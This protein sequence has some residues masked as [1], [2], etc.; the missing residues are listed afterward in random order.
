LTTRTVALTTLTILLLMLLT[1]SMNIQKVSAENT[2][3][4]KADGSVDPS[5]AQIQRDIDVYT[6]RGDI[7]G[8][9]VI[10][11]NNTII[12]GKDFTL[13]GNGTDS[14]IYSRGTHNLTV[15]NLRI[16]KFSRGVYI[17]ESPNSKITSNIVT[18]CTYGLL[19]DRSPQTTI[20]DNIV[21]NNAWDGIFITASP[22]SVLTN[23]T[24]ANH[25]KWGI[26]LGYSSGSTLQ[27]NQMKNNSYNFGVSVDF[28]HNIDTSNTINNKPIYY[29][30][31]EQNKQVPADAGYVAII[32]SYKIKVRSLQLSRNGQSVLIVSS[33]NS[34][35]ENSNITNN[36]YYGIQIVNSNN[37]DIFNNTITNSDLGGI[38]LISSKSNTIINNTVKT[39]G[40]GIY[41]DASNNNM[42]Y[43]NNF[44]N[45]TY[46][47]FTQDS[48]NQ[49][50]SGQPLSGNYWS[51]YNGEDTDKD[52]TGDT[53]YIIDR[54]NKD[55]YPLVTTVKETNLNKTSSE[56][57]LLVIATVILISIS[58]IA[59]LI[60]FKKK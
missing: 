58:A 6:F 48:T 39:N 60:Y 40:K 18:N 13:E 53:P 9:I 14:G 54:T 50:D 32:N 27:Y 28:I 7:Y 2:I 16:T 11:R 31:N 15:R 49:W 46:Q 43:Q 45:N 3:Y 20:T 56:P 38:A 55:N 26:Y 30:I 4:I 35:V 12:D 41:L 22:N 51:D 37:N 29:W 59:I 19:I 23:N 52:G 34:I 8:S 24:V 1:F 33:E 17:Q 25:N 42:I 47:A 36:G 5:T 10:Q 57:I 44:I 21:T